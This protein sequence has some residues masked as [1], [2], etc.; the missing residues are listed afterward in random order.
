VY[1]ALIVCNSR[2][3]DTSS[4]AELYGPK[5]DGMLLRDA[6]TDHDAGLFDKQDIRLLVE[7]GSLEAGRAID[8]FFSAAEPDDILLF[9]YSGHGRVQ[10]QQLFLCSK[11]TISGRLHSTA[12]SGSTLNA[13]VANSF[14]QAKIII[15]DCC[16]SGFLREKGLT[17]S[18]AGTGRYVIGA[19]SATERA[20]DGSLRGT[21]S[22]FT[23]M[24]SEALVS[25]AKDR[26]AD[27][28]IDLDDVYQYLESAPYDGPRPQRIFDG[29][30]AIAIARRRESE[31]TVQ[32]IL[33]TD[34][35]D[36]D[37]TQVTSVEDLAECMRRLRIR[38]DGPSFRSLEYRT[39]LVSGLLPGTKIQRVPLRR[40][41][42][43][44]VLQ[45][46]VFPTKRLLLT[47]VEACGVD[48]EV[49][50]RWEQAWDRLA[51]AL[52]SKREAGYIGDEDNDQTDLLL[53][54]YIPSERLYAAEADRL[55][56]L[57]HDWLMTS[58]GHGVR[59][60]G[61][62]TASG[63]MYEFFADASLPNADLRDEFN[64]FSNF[65]MLCSTDASA[66]A[67]M[68]APMGLRGAS[69]VDFVARF[70]REVRRLQID[71]A[72]E[73]E[74]RILTIRQNLETELVDRGV[75][76]RTVPST[77]INAWIE[78]LVPG[79]SASDSL[80]L[81]AV[82]QSVQTIPPVT[83]NINQQFID[84]V[85]ST[86]IQNVRGTVQLGS[87]AKEFLE[88]IDRFGGHEAPLL[89]AA[90]YELEDTDAPPAKRSAAKRRLKKF[91]G[92]VAGMVHDVGIDLL[93]KYLESKIGF[94]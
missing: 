47:F 28:F 43:A 56:S 58:R 26:D 83:L 87:R 4:F 44:A 14:A 90:V 88:L 51:S 77:Q 84:A 11:N 33:S 60:A 41:T 55:L 27:G 75:E 21:A 67:D 48:L 69:S 68:L 65:L 39:K 5:I 22:P 72:H 79:P 82:P 17:D 31:T 37:P 45:G 61:Y 85:E 81:L 8:D 74:R 35:S 9:Y 3:D 78:R 63:Q 57:F 62:R 42:L 7:E 18:V 32:R 38:S 15:L 19:A 12:I 20:T 70:G 36:L 76:L 53:R 49:D 1:R 66:A 94:K 92:Q 2:F 73:R 30:G 34:M 64:N 71:L 91:L 50:R 52:E 23:R 29:T 89:E 10:N 6:L 24:L 40:S 86:V 25:K 46:K 16:F 93:A 59:Q 13:I 80:A 54:V